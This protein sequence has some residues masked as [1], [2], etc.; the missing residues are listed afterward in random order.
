VVDYGPSLGESSAQSA[1][2]NDVHASVPHGEARAPSE[3]LRTLTRRYI[4]DPGT[5]IET[6]DIGPNRYGRRK[7][8]I[9]LEVTDGV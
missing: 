3:G 9:V 1:A 2:G 4:L 7:I 6:V 5:R 8:I